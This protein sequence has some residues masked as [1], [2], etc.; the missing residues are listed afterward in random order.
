MSAYLKRC[1]HIYK[2]ARHNQAMKSTQNQVHFITTNKNDFKRRIKDNS[3]ITNGSLQNQLFLQRTTIAG[4]QR[5]SNETA[6][7]IP[8]IPSQSTE[9]LS[10]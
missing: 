7:K 3:S 9:V 4:C 5:H 8:S 6:S 1:P 2:R 10:F